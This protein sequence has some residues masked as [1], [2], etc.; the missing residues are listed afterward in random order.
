M[1]RRLVV[2]VGS[3]SL[4]SPDGRLDIGRLV[5]LTNAISARHRESSVVLVSSGAIAAGMGPLGLRRR[6]KDLA[7]QQAAASVGQGA[8]VAAYQQ[9]FGARGVTVG[10]VLLTIDD[11]TRRSHYLNARRTLER[12]LELQ[13]LG[14]GALTP[15]QARHQGVHYKVR[16]RYPGAPARQNASA[17]PEAGPQ[18][19]AYSYS[20]S[21][22][23]AWLRP[24]RVFDDGRFTYI[25]LSHD[26]PLHGGLPAVFGRQQQDSGDFIINSSYQHGRITVHGVYPYL[27]LRHGQQVLGL[28]RE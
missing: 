8:L 27:V 1:A 17:E 3:S 19:D 26:L 5:A 23:A 21:E 24:E 7:T 4:T 18:H 2:K 11:V 12:L 22:D 10:Q 13:V 15:A 6:P 25:D 20:A 14:H 9:A 16:F 28:R